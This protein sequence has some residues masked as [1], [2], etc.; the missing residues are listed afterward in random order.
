MFVAESAV[1]FA[2]SV[3]IAALPAV[4]EPMGTA[5]PVAVDVDFASAF[6]AAG[7]FR[8][9]PTDRVVV[10]SEGGPALLRPQETPEEP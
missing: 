2:A 3:A 7:R 10:L 9:V 5:V 4:A 6:S 1:D 8:E